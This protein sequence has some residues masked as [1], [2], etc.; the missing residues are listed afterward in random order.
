MV[1][2]REAIRLKPDLADAHVGLG[3]ALLQEGRADD[4]IAA[5]REAIR[6]RPNDAQTHFS[7]GMALTAM[8][9]YDDAIAALRQ[10]TLLEPDYAEAHGALGE[11]LMRIGEFRDA[12]AEFRTCHELGSRRPGWH[13]PSA[14]LVAAAEQRIDDEEDLASQLAEH[15]ATGT[16]PEDPQ[17]LAAMAR[18]ALAKRHP[19]IAAR[20]LQ[21]AFEE[22]P[23]L[24]AAIDAGHQRLAARA[25]VLA[26]VGGTDS[27]PA[28]DAAG[29]ATWRLQALAWLEAELGAIKTASE[30]KRLPPPEV[31]FAL[32]PLTRSPDFASVRGAE[33]LAQVPEAER[34]RWK[35]LW[36]DIDALLSS[37]DRKPESRAPETR[38]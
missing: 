20:W 9:L 29:R 21:L 28:I 38:R 3:R 7:A 24:A 6:L 12:L 2:Y 37:L 33:A 25:A 8:G 17:T 13:F 19:A 26:S 1:H 5:Y 32:V 10:A 18:V 36:A 15:L 4:A 27:A 11:R 22:A 23:E 35:K 34:E 31:R 14:D 16:K 30:A